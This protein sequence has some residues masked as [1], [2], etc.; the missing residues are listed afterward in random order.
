MDHS[1]GGRSRPCPNPKTF[2]LDEV[3]KLFLDSL[4]EHLDTPDLLYSYAKNYLEERRRLNASRIN[5][6]A[7]IE[8]QRDA[9]SKDVTRLTEWALNGLGDHAELLSRAKAKGEERDRLTLELASMGEQESNIDIHPA[10]IRHYAEEIFSVRQEM[11]RRGYDFD[12]D[13]PVSAALRELIGSI[14]VYRGRDGDDG[15]SI[16][17]TG[18]LDAVMRAPNAYGVKL[19][20]ED[21]CGLGGPMSAVP[22]P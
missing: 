12:G 20:A 11:Q 1:E 22:V 14:T 2:Y 10:A 4:F 5:R 21:R 19:V 8:A 13:G 3:E 7:E 18:W 15:L 17:V 9:A 6:R 16:K